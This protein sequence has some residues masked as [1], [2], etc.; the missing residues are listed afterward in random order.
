[1]GI[2][3]V[4]LLTGCV[5][6]DI[7]WGGTL[8][9][10]LFIGV[11][12]FF[13]VLEYCDIIIKNTSIRPFRFLSGVFAILVTGMHCLFFNLM[14]SVDAGLFSQ[15]LIPVLTIFV[16]AVIVFQWR[17]YEK[18]QFVENIGATLTAFF[19]VIF[20]AV[21]LYMIPVLADTVSEGCLRVFAAIMT[22][23]MY[24]IGGFAGGKMFGRRKIFP[25]LSPGKTLEG[26]IGGFLLS[27]SAAVFL[28]SMI[29]SLFTVPQAILFAG[30]AGVTE[31]G[32]AHV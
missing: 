16:L 14:D 28:F 11:F 31:I 32:R 30:A 7:R 27:G 3:A 5:Y 8:F 24:D 12:A 4:L 25:V 26:C 20:P 15:L 22:V 1:M 6:A 18:D 13:C 17:K 2:A 29:L 10:T 21:A 9:F 19:L 23:K